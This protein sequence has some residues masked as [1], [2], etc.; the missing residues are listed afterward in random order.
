MCSKI[1]FVSKSFVVIVFVSVFLMALVLI[2]GVFQVILS[3][4][5]HG[6]DTRLMLLNDII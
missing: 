1:S 4:G 3:D 6:S 2:S 5:H